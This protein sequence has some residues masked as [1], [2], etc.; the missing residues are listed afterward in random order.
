MRKFL[1]IALALA[2][3]VCFFAGTASADPDD[4]ATREVEVYV[5][6]TNSLQENVGTAQYTIQLGQVEVH[7]PFRVD[8]NFESVYLSIW[9]TD[10]FK[11]D[12]TGAPY[13]LPLVTDAE[14]LIYVA[15]ELDPLTGETLGG[16]CVQ[17]CTSD[18][19]NKG[20]SLAWGGQSDQD[21]DGTTWTG[22]DS[23]QGLFESAHRGHFSHDLD[24]VL[25]WGND[26]AE[27]P[28]GFY[29]GYVR[30]FGRIGTF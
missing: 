12:Q 14:A 30:L 28:R 20:G 5:D 27:L 21:V 2:V 24:V 19:A 1:A 26:D 23:A 15:A 3:G 16:S 18:L 17:G 22:R 4:A 29:S 13:S 10:L 9:A 11:A 25:Q 6:G 8:A 7:V